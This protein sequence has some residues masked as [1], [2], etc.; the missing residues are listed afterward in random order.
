MLGA[1]FSIGASLVGSRMQRSSAKDAN[2]AN[3]RL[4]AEN[5][6]WQERMS[7]TAHQREV[8]EIGRAHV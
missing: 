3:I 6:A 8:Q 2:Q 7:N 4:A 5:R 1:L